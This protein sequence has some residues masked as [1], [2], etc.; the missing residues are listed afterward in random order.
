MHNAAFRK[1]GSM[2]PFASLD[3]KAGLARCHVR[4]L[5]Q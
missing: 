3:A 2:L 5:E 1:K 4:N